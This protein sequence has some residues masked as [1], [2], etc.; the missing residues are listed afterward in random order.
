[1]LAI[2]PNPTFSSSVI[3]LVK[4]LYILLI[5]YFNENVWEPLVW[6]MKS[7]QNCLAHTAGANEILAVI[8]VT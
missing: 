2:P 3:I 5:L 1:M 7:N 4:L 6:P 8:L